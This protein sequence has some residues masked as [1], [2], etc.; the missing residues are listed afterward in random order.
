MMWIDKDHPELDDVK[1]CIKE[2]YGRYGITAVRSDEIEH[3]G[4]ITERIL[5][6]IASAE[7]LIADL[8]GERP[9]VYYEV[10]YAHA[11]GKRPSLYRREGTRLH[12]DLTVHN[13]PEYKNI[14][15]LR[16]KLN[17]RLATHKQN[18][19]RSLNAFDAQ[20]RCGQGNRKNNRATV[21]VRTS[22][23]RFCLLPSHRRCT[24]FVK[25]ARR[26]LPPTLFIEGLKRAR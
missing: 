18:C 22:R 6:E 15:D 1:D 10:G 13:C 25:L 12:F 26:P 19:D 7:F 2:V 9:S 21:M 20:G 17:A 5:D 11:L 24:S 14:G 16:E 3:S 8:T 4:V 23:N